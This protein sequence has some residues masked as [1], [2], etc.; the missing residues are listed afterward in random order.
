MMP[1]EL[2]KAEDRLKHQ[3]YEAID[4]ELSTCSSGDLLALLDSKSRKV[5]DTAATWL[6]RRK[7]TKLLV[8]ALV[9]DRIHTAL[10]RVRATNILNWFGL[11]APEA[12][13]AYLYL[14]S[15]SSADVVDNALF[16]IVFARRRDLLPT[17]R[18]HL[19]C[20]PGGS[21][22]RED[23]TE[24]IKALEAN[25][26]SLFSRGFLDAGNVWRLNEPAPPYTAEEKLEVD[27][28]GENTDG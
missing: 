5:A 25:D 16:G 22:R 19:E 28:K 8:N 1:D 23:F 24:A 20:L 7:E 21:P 3:S 12:V 17:L 15:D 9:S 27:G 11:A 2:K 4:H 14:L 6:D 26:P 13:K 10:G 18:E